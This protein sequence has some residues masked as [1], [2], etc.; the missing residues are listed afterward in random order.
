MGYF[1]DTTHFGNYIKKAIKNSSPEIASDSMSIDTY[2]AWIYKK[3]YADAYGYA[4]RQDSTLLTESGVHEWLSRHSLMESFNHYAEYDMVKTSEFESALQEL[5][6]CAGC[7]MFFSR[8]DKPLYVGV[9]KDLGSRASTSFS[10]RFSHYVDPVFFRY[11][12]SKT[13]SDSC[14]LEAYFI[15][16]LKPVLNSTG[17]FDDELT[18][19]IDIDIPINRIQCNKEGDK[20]EFYNKYLSRKVTM[21]KSEFE[22]YQVEAK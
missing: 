18:I 20:V 10:E 11:I 21:L 13:A 1:V 4:V 14:V 2:I 3:G 5:D 7:Y 15:A 8:A 17:K 12:K 22:E 6:G 19:N 9:S 16:K